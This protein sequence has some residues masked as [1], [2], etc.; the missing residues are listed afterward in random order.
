MGQKCSG[1]AYATHSGP[2]TWD[3]DPTIN[4][5]NAHTQ[6][7]GRQTCLLDPVPRTTEGLYPLY[8]NTLRGCE[9]HLQS[10]GPIHSIPRF[11]YIK[12]KGNDLKR[13]SPWISN[14]IQRR[15]RLGT[16]CTD[17]H[18]MHNPSSTVAFKV[19]SY[20]THTPPPHTHTHKQQQPW[21]SR[22]KESFFVCLFVFM[23][24]KFHLEDTMKQS[25]Q[26]PQSTLRTANTSSTKTKIHRTRL[27]EMIIYW[28]FLKNVTF[29]FTK[30][31]ETRCK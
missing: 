19:K 5:E 30:K 4:K 21:Q 26:A 7:L 29:Y 10:F 27:F 28:F 14:A 23:T 31:L 3:K 18:G 8:K 12:A 15:K 20:T 1:I 11:G 2:W 9:I 13:Q 25:K 17:R 6:I 22:R 24:K 16:S